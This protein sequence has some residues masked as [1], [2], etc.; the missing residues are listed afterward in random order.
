MLHKYYVEW[1]AP[2]YRNAGSTMVMASNKPDA[3]QKAK[4][5]L[6]NRVK[7]QYLSRFDAWRTPVRPKSPRYR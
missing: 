6:G 3:I 4:K 2:N 5:K 1:S 7:T